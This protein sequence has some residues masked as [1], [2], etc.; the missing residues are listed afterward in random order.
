MGDIKGLVSSYI[1]EAGI[2]LS[3]GFKKGG[4]ALF[5]EAHQIAT[6]YGYMDLVKKI[7]S[8]LNSIH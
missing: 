7:E 2:M 3:A 1:N 4:R 5:E 6:Q 8:F